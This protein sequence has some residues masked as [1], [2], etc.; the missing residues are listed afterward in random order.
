MRRVS[1]PESYGFDITHKEMAN[2]TGFLKDAVGKALE[3]IR[4]GFADVIR[5]IIGDDADETRV[6]LCRI[7]IMAQCL[8]PLLRERRRL[9]SGGAAHSNGSEHLL[10]DVDRLAGHV[11]RFSLAGI[12]GTEQPAPA[13]GKRKPRKHL[14]SV[15]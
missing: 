7:S 2:P 1:D 6:Q 8:H 14:K 9:Q 13:A 12:R 3:P 15:R 4:A 5:E 11:T 10:K